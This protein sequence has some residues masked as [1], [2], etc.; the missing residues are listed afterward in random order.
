MKNALSLNKKR[1]S[2]HSSPTTHLM[3]S[4]TFLMVYLSLSYLVPHIQR[5]NKSG[6]AARQRTT[7][8]DEVMSMWGFLGGHITHEPTIPSERFSPAPDVATPTMDIGGEESSSGDMSGLSVTSIQRRKQLLK[9][10]RT[11]RGE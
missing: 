3:I 8:E 5:K 1:S 10:R 7:R 2:Q 4:P 6:A 11:E 9:Q